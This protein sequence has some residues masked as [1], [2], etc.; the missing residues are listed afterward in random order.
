MGSSCA[1]KGVG[2]LH[3]NTKGALTTLVVPQRAVELGSQ[4]VHAL[5]CSRAQGGC[6]VQRPHLLLLPEIKVSHE[7]VTLL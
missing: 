5:E 4:G 2:S 6:K 7:A 3:V 1:G